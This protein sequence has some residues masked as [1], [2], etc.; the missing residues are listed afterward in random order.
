MSAREEIEELNARIGDIQTRND[1]LAMAEFYVEDAVLL[2][3]QAEP[4]KGKSAIFDHWS[5]NLPDVAHFT[6]TTREVEI[7]S[8]TSL[9]E[10][11]VYRTATKADETI[12]TGKYLV[13]WRR[14]GDTWK[15]TH[16]MWSA[17]S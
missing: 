1:A 7:L 2:P 8:A 5:A 13:I 12:L 11:G 4:I 16:D 9:V 6:S 15:I 14:V 3:P 10:Q 17:L